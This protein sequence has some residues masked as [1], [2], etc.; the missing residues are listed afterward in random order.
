MLASIVAVETNIIVNAI[1]VQHVKKR[2]LLRVGQTCSRGF[3]F[4]KIRCLVMIETAHF[5][6]QK[7][8][9]VLLGQSWE[10]C[11]ELSFQRVLFN[12]LHELIVAQELLVTWLPVVGRLRRSCTVSM[13][14]VIVQPPYK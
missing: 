14:L 12:H 5:L 11:L 4:E 1:F 13:L 9:I 8:S 2:D 10:E 7:L 6:V 3:Y